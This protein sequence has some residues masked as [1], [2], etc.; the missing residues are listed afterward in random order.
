MEEGTPYMLLALA[1]NV[2]TASSFP[3]S[4]FSFVIGRWEIDRGFICKSN[5]AGAKVCPSQVSGVPVDLSFV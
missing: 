3:V 1:G 4:W 2:Q 5:D